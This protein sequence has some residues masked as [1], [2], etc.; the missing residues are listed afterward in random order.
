MTWRANEPYNDL[1]SLPPAI[2]VEP[3]GVLKATI[4]ARA[5]L[6]SL[7]QAARRIANPAVLINSIPLL[8]AQASSEIENIVTT[9]DEL[10]R[11]A[12]DEAAATNPATKETLS[13]RTALFAGVSL[14]RSRPLS[15]TTAAEICAIVKNREMPIRRLPGT[16]IGNPV[17]KMAIY[18]PP[19]GEA[20]IRDKLSDWERFIHARDG[21]DPLVVMALAHYQFEA[22]HPFEDGNGRTGRILNVLMLMGAGLIDQPI[23]YLSR[24]IIE[25][26]DEYYR[27]LL[28]V[29]QD[30]AWTDWI[31]FIIEG[32]RQT[33]VSTVIKIDQIQ[34][35]QDTTL[36]KI[37]EATGGAN[38]DL[39]AVL[40]EQPYCRIANVIERCGVSRPTATNWLNS[41][42]DA[43]VLVD[44]RRGRE[45]IFIN[46][47]LLDLL[48]RS[49]SAVVAESQ[50]TL[51]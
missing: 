23:L 24:Y 27:L 41:L 25:N 1:R 21:I 7:D 17:T 6:A 37:R 14:I 4:E 11:F 13:Y 29:T 15:V 8:E 30:A 20:R 16:F 39:L 33:A 40:F 2:E 26:K 9:T 34:A 36:G 46:T 49:D 12:H 44:V 18:T 35:L 43:R 28:A 31:L 3:R 5:A 42:V 38:A 32:I 47:A 48:V 45:R 10:F 50:P 22:I 51:F 19:V